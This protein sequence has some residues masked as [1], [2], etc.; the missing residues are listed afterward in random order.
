MATFEN[1]YMTPEQRAAYSSYLQKQCIQ[2]SQERWARGEAGRLCQRILDAYNEYE[3]YLKQEYTAVRDAEYVE[4]ASQQMYVKLRQNLRKADQAARC[5]H[6]KSNGQ[7]CGSP[8]MGGAE[9]CYAHARVAESRSQTLDLPSL[10]DANGV[11][12]A[13]MKIA[14][15]LIDGEVE[16]KKATAIAYLVQTAAANVGR[17]DFGDEE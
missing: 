11:Q 3:A 5:T 9:L 6:I 8:R 7:P 14:K 13:L 16:S 10:E 12:L 1:D 15:W 2:A 4:V 17:V